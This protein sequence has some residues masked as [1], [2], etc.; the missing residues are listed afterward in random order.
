[1][2]SSVRIEA[3]IANVSSD[4]PE[5]RG[6]GKSLSFLGKAK[7]RAVWR[8]VCV[9]TTVGSKTG[10][11]FVRLG[12]FCEFNKEVMTWLFLALGVSGLR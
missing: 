6:M 10:T 12:R 9:E 4:D 3:E 1:M 11:H 5:N 8:E 2:S 7:L